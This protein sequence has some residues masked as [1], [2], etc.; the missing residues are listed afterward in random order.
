MTE[1]KLADGAVNTDKIAEEAVTMDKLSTADANDGDV[2]V[3]SRTQGQWIPGTIGGLSGNGNNVTS[4]TIGD[5]LKTDGG[6]ET[7]TSSGT[8]HLDFGHYEDK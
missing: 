1:T 2:I 5:G 3:Y 6:D 4:L 8:V 7:I